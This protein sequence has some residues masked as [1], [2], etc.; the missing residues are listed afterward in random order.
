MSYFLDLFSPETH[1][2]FGRSDRTVTGF[3]LAHNTIAK[4]VR[5]GDK[6][7][8][9]LTRRSRWVGI[10]RVLDGPFR[11]DTPLLMNESDPFVIRFHVKTLVWLPSGEGLPIHDE[12]IWSRLSFTKDRARTNPSWTGA[13]RSSLSRINDGDGEFLE[14]LLSKRASEAGSGAGEPTRSPKARSQRP[15]TS[16]DRS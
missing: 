1:E 5:P 15:R 12:T 14:S 4:R 3:R 9:Y 6:F 13:I 16:G 8:C 11:D 7:V 2:T 10:L